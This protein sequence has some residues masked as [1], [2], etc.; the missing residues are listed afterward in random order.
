[1]RDFH[2]D[3]FKVP[4]VLFIGDFYVL[5]SE[6]TSPDVPRPSDACR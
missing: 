1:M 4:R 6:T 2:P 3:H 5:P